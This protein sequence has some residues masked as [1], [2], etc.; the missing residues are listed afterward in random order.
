MI[1][2]SICFIIWMFCAIQVSIRDVDRIMEMSETK[3]F[4]WIMLVALVSP[5]ALVYDLIKHGWNNDR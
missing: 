3:L 1:I 4:F 2:V 5:I